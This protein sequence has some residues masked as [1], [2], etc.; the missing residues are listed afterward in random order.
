[1]HEADQEA[2]DLGGL[3]G[4][5]ASHPVEAAEQLAPRSDKSRLL[6]AGGLLLGVLVVG[7]AFIASYV[8]A[9]HEPQP[10]D[11]PVGVVSADAG[12]RTLLGQLGQ[13]TNRLR[14][15][16]FATAQDADR[17]LADRRVYAVLASDP[18]AHGLRLTVASGAAPGIADVVTQTVGAATNVAHVPLAVRDAHPTSA[19]DPRGL[20]PFYLV[21]GW[22]LGGYLAA[23]A[24]AVVLGTVPRGPVRLGTRLAAFAAFAVLSGLAGALLTGPGYG[25]WPAHLGALWL[26]G[27]L[28]VFAAA[29]V[30][31]A[32]ESWIGLIGTGAAM[33]LLFV[34]GNPG[35]G[36]VYPPELLPT[37][38]RTMHDWLPTGMAV[39]LVRAVE[40]FGGG[41]AAW[42]LVGLVL[43]SVG[44]LAALQGATLAYP[45]RHP[46]PAPEP[47]AG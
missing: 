17:A 4:R 38:F 35:S 29:A 39:E 5:L 9:L 8:G 14:T 34:L 10:R 47:A 18:A 31:A 6:R 20:T 36:G 44:G 32:L 16:V 23:T 11:I 41:G 37:F 42:P 27:S 22:L 30:T 7:T 12:A 45:G 21:V 33:L 3:A 28:V 24:L 43:W 1:M 46:R 26:T 40:Y 15:T 2:T 19:S 25:I 13:R